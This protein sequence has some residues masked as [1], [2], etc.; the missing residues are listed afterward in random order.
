[1]TFDEFKNAV[2]RHFMRAKN[3]KDKTAEDTGAVFS[4]EVVVNGRRIEICISQPPVDKGAW[5]AWPELPQKSKKLI[6][7]AASGRV[8]LR[9]LAAVL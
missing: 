8:A 5:S 7:G 9:R 3:F 1:M 2:R 4:V 6:R